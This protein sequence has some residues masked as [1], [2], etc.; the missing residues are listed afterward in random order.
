MY[1]ERSVHLTFCA[2]P[3]RG[4]AAKGGREVERERVEEDF[5]PF[6]V[7]AVL[8]PL[9]DIYSPGKLLRWAGS[10]EVFVLL[11]DL[12]LH[13]VPSGAILLRHGWDFSSVVI[14]A[15]KR[16]LDLFSYGDPIQ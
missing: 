4:S 11:S 3:P 5:L 7:P 8:P 15:D 13:L 6:L 10:R 1:Q 9:P 12:K 16:D 2:S 14:V